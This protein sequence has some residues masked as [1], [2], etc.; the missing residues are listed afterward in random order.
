M[1][2]KQNNTILHKELR[3]GQERLKFAY[4][5]MENVLH[6]LHVHFSFLNFFKAL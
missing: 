5:T 1:R 2:L 6:A 3:R 4:L